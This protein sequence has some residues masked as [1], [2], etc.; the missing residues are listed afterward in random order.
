[1]NSSHTSVTREV[2]KTPPLINRHGRLSQ[3]FV[4]GNNSNVMFKPSICS[5]RGKLNI[6]TSTPKD[7]GEAVNKDKALQLAKNICQDNNHSLADIS[8]ALTRSEANDLASIEFAKTLLHTDEE[9]PPINWSTH[10]G[11][12]ALKNSPSSLSN[13]TMNDACKPTHKGLIHPQS[14]AQITEIVVKTK[15]IVKSLE[16]NGKQIRAMQHRLAEKSAT[17]QTF[18]E[19]HHATMAEFSQRIRSKGNYQHYSRLTDDLQATSQTPIQST[20]L[21]SVSSALPVTVVNVKRKRA[22]IVKPTSQSHQASLDP[23]T[24][25]SNRSSNNKARITRSTK[26]KKILDAVSGK[27]YMMPTISSC[28][29]A[30]TRPS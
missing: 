5:P 23:Q 25:A 19:K 6:G 2:N 17:L 28:A 16:K 24:N 1:M 11:L 15:N 26:E 4:C 20:A 12:N 27:G 14:S 8:S 21:P 29:K 22:T 13:S 7:L 18:A 10:P 3:T 30:I 9:L